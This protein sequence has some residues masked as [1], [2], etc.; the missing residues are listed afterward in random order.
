MKPVEP[1]L[2][3]HFPD[4]GGSGDQGK[5]LRERRGW[6]E[7]SLQRDT[8][9]HPQPRESPAVLLGEEVG[10]YTVRQGAQGTAAHWRA[11]GLIWGW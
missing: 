10:S 8:C 9:F 5:D 1:W 6:E 2:W 11:W 7:A 3:V 4:L